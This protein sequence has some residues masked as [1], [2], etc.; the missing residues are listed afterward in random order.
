MSI[1][2]Q[3]REQFEEER[4]QELSDSGSCNI[5]GCENEAVTIVNY[6]VP[7]APTAQEPPEPPQAAV[8]EECTS[9]DVLDQKFEKSV[10]DDCGEKYYP[11]KLDSSYVL[12]DDGTCPNCIVE[13]SEHESY[14]SLL[15][16]LRSEVVQ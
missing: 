15:H 3:D 16:E 9:S 4:L 2:E 7:L 12:D 6:T 13:F 10:C 11:K 5:E 14:R 8:C 1:Q